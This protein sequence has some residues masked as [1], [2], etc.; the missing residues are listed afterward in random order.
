MLCGWRRLRNRTPVP[1]PDWRLQSTAFPHRIFPFFI[2]F[3]VCCRSLS[4]QRS[5]RRTKAWW[6]TWK[7]RCLAAWA[8]SSAPTAPTQPRIW[9]KRS[10]QNNFGCWKYVSLK[11]IEAVFCV[12]KGIIYFVIFSE[13]FVYFKKTMSEAIKSCT[14]FLNYDQPGSFGW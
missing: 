14:F 10:N 12:Y 6:V 9:R 1:I 2:Q 4:C 8:V 7:R 13:A 11:T 5:L 3:S